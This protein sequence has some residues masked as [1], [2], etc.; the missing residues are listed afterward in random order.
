[1]AWE[2][3]RTPLVGHFLL[4][5]SAFHEADPDLTLLALLLTWHP[6]LLWVQPELSLP[7]EVIPG[8]EVP[9]HF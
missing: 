1:M 2:Y 5:R 7:K 4:R 8:P 9:L 3:L 6:P